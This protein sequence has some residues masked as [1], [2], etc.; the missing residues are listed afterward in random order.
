MQK[1]LR[2]QEK[3]V[4]VKEITD[5]QVFQIENQDYFHDY[6]DSCSYYEYGCSCSECIFNKTAELKM[7]LW[8][9]HKNK[10]SL[11]SLKDLF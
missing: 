6:E 1:Y 3:I 11:Q 5:Y 10:L 8:E 9:K 2:N 4:K 7:R